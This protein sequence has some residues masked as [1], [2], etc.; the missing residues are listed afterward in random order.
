M[1]TSNPPVAGRP[2]RREAAVI[3]LCCLLAS[4]ALLL[5][6]SQSS[7]LYPTNTW[8]D[9]NCLLTVGRAMRGGRVL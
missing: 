8:V 2:A 7:P 1:S 5:L 9:A 4:G 6:C 3:L